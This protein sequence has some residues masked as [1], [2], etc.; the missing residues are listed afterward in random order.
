MKSWLELIIKWLRQSGIKVYGG[1]MEIWIFHSE[2][3]PPMKL[4]V[5]CNKITSK[6]YMN[7]LGVY[8]NSKL[9]W[10]THVEKAITKS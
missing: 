5:N 2:D 10:Q 4:T 8:F 3:F 1:K 9:N 7:V 6:N